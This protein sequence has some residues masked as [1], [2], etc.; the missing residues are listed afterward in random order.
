MAREHEIVSAPASALACALVSPVYFPG[1]AA[2][3][4]NGE[5]GTGDKPSRLPP[6]G[7]AAMVPTEEV[8]GRYLSET[9]CI[10]LFIRYIGDIDVSCYHIA[11]NEVKPS[12][13]TS[14][15]NLNNYGAKIGHIRTLV[16][17]DAESRSHYWLSVFAQDHGVVP[18]HGRQEV[19]V[20]VA[21]ENDNTPLTE[22]PVYYPSIAENSP[23]GKQVVQLRAV[24]FDRDPEQR[25]SFRITAGNPES[26][27]SIDRE[28][29]IIRTTGR[30]LD[31]ENQA[32][33]IL[34]VTVSDNGSPPLSST[35]RVVVTVA[36]VNDHA[37]QFEQSFY[38]IQIPESTSHDLPLFQVLGYD[39]DEGPNGDIT[40]SIKSGRGIGKFRIHPKTGVVYSQRGFQEGQEYDLRIRAQDNGLPQKSHTTR[41]SVQVMKVP[42][43]SPHPPEI[44]NPNQTVEVTESDDITYLV[45]L[46]QAIDDDGDMLWYDI[47]GGDDDHDFF[48]GRDKG[49]I[50][51]AKK[52]DWERK[53]KYNLTISV[54]D[55]VHTV[56]TQLYVT[57]IDINDCRPNFSEKVY[58]VE[59][60]E[61]VEKG[62]EILQL[63][64]T[65]DDEDKKVFYS[66]YAARNPASLSIFK[67]DSV[68]GAVVLNEKLDRETIE[69]HILTVM[70]KDQGTPSKRNY[71]RVVVTVHDHND[72]HPEFTSQII[73]GK[74]FETA[75]IGSAVVQVYA[76]DKDRGENAKIT[77]SITS[78]N[79][80][81]VFSIDPTLGT[82]QIAR[83]LDLGSMSE[84]MLIVKATDNGSPPLSSTIPVHVMVTMADNAPP[85]FMK[86]EHAAEIYENQPIG[87]YV[88]HLEARSTSSLFFEIIAG[89]TDDMYFINPSTG[90]IITKRQ[91]DY[92]L[93][94]VYNLT[95]E[96]TNMAG[97]KAKCNVIVHVLDRND[98]APRFVQALYMGSISEAAPVG[99]L[100][101]ANNSS[102]LVIKAKDDD[103]ELNALL[104][105]DIV[106]TLPRTYFRIDSST[107]A[108]RTVMALDHEKY[109]HFHFHVKV[110]DLGKPRL[111]SETTARVE[112][113]I[114]DVN[115]CSPHFLQSEYNTTL[116]L[117]TYQNVAVVRVNASDPDSQENT[118]LRYDIIDGNKGNVFAIDAKSGVVTVA[119]TRHIKQFHKL[120]LRVSDGKFSS[121][122][123][124]NIKVEKSE[125]SGLTFQKSVY[126]GTILENT[127]KISPVV[128]VNVLGSALNEHVVFSILNPTDMFTIGPTSGVIK[129]TGKRFDRELKDKYELIVEARSEEVDEE[130]PR[131]AHVMVNVTILDINDN[132]PMFVNLP[133]YAVVSVDAQKGDGI[134]KV[135]AV[136]MDKGENGEVRYELI[137]GHGELFKVCRKTGEVTLKQSLE[138]HNREYELIIAAY[139]GGISPCS[140]EVPV[141]VKV[142]DRSM[143]IFDKQFYTDSVP[144]S[145]EIHSPLTV[146]IQAE[147]PLGRKLIYSIVKGNDYEEF[148]LDFNTGVISV[149]DELDY[150]QKKQYELTI[151]ATDSV[152]GVYAEVLVSILVQDVNDCPPEFSTD[153]YNISV[154]EAAPFGTS[155]LKVSSRD[156]DTGIN[157]K[158]R[159]EIQGDSTNSSEYFHIDPDDGT[160]YLKR[161]LDHEIHNS[162]HFTVVAK[163][164]GVPSLSSTAHVWVTVLDM[165]DNPPK[166]EQPSYTCFLS[167][168]AQRGQ[169]VTVV[170]ASDP[171]YVD[172]ERLSYTIVGG[173]EL[174]TFSIDSA[175][176]IISLINMQ[177]FAEDTMS[178]LN[179][180]VTDGVYTSFTRV[181]IE[182]LP[183]N[184]HNPVF[185]KLQFEVK[186]NEN[187]PH[188]TMVTKVTA[189]DEDFGEYGEITYAIPSELLREIFD[190]NRKSGEITTK[191][192]LDREVQ[193]LYEIPVMATDGG[194]RSGFV[195][196]RVKV[197]DEN[198]NTPKFL[199][200]EYKA[201]IQNNLTI[202]SRILRIKAVD[203]DDDMAAD[204]LYSI[205]ETQTSG[206]K[207]L[208]TI[209]NHSGV[210]TLNRSAVP[211]ENQV[212]QF[213]VR[214]Q[215]RGS[216]SLYSNV[217]VDIYVMS[218]QD[219]AP[220]FERRDDK[221][222]ISE[223]D[224]PGTLITKLKM[225]TN[226]S[227]HYRIISGNE[228][229]PLF[230]VDSQGQLSLARTLDREAKDTHLIAVLAETDSS[231]PL[232]A[233]AEVTL[234][235]LDENDNM[236]E[237]ESS[238][239]RL[240]LA[241]NVGEGTSILKVIAHDRDLGSNGEVRY[242]FGSD[243]GD[244]ANVFAVDAYTGWITTL[245]QLDK[246]E[247]S[248]F[249]FQVV[250]TD[251]GNPKHFA[252][253]S[254]YIKLKDYNDNPPVFK[255]RHDEATVN[256]D[257]LPGTVVVQLETTDL[258]SDLISPVEF[259]IT[260]GDPQSQFQIR[261]TGEV[262][263]A[264]PLDR[265]SISKYI[266]EVTATD[267]KFIAKTK[268]R[269]REV[270][271]EGVHP[272][273]YVLTVL[274]N[275]IDEEPNANLRYYL[276][277][278][279]ADRFSLDKSGGHL[280]TI[281]PLDREEQSKYQ[282]TAHVQDRDKTGWECSSQIEILISDLNDNPPEFSMHSYSATLPEDVEVGTLV[283]KVHATDRDIGIN[284]KIKY[285][286]VDSAN[287]HFKIASDSGIVT[288]AKPLDRETRAM[289]NLSVQAI[290]QGTPQ[291]SKL[292]GLTV[293][294]LDIND[295]P[296]EFASKY[297]YASVPE[298]NAVGT[299]IVRVLATSKDA[300]VNAEVSYSIIGGN[301]H[302]KFAIHPKSGVITIADHLDYERAKDYFLTIQAVDGGVPPLSNHATVNISVTD[303]NDNAPVFNQVSYSARIREDAQIGDKI[304]QVL[305]T[306]L[307]SEANGKVTYS[308]ERGDRQKQFHINEKTGYISVAGT[309]DREM[310]SNYVLEVHA[311]DN[312]LPVMSS[313]VMVNIEISDA[314][315]N[316]PL[317]SQANYTAIVQ[318]DKPLH[319]MVLKFIVTDADANPNAAPYTYDIRS[320]NEGTAFML[321]QDGILRT[322]AKLNHKIRDK[323]YLHIR[324]FDN[325][326]P[327]LFSDT[328]VIVK[329]IEESQYPPHIT[330]LEISVN[331][332]MDEF[333]GGVIGKIHASDQDQFD[334]LSYS[335]AKTPTGNLLQNPA[336][337]LF[338][339]NRNDGTL[340]ALPRLD[341]GEY[342]INISVSD[343]KF[344]SNAIVKVSV[345][346]VSE[347]MLSNS[348]IIR[349]RDISPLDFV[350]SY[351]KGFRRA[352]GNSL[353]GRLKDVII[354]SIQPTSVELSKSKGRYT[355]QAQNSDLDVLFAVKKSQSVGGNT[356][357]HSADT[358]RQAI[359]GNIDEIEAGGLV[360]EEIARDKCTQSYCTYGECEDHI[361]LDKTSVTSISADFTSFV[362]PYHHHEVHCECKEGYAGDRCEIIVNE[363][364]RDPCP[365][366][367]VCI[368]DA[369]PQG[370]SCQCPEGFAGPTCEVDISKCHDESCYIPRNPVSFS[371]KS[372]AQYRV[373]NSLVK[374]ILENRMSL[375][376]RIRTMH[377]TGNLMYAAGKVDYNILEVENGVVQYRFDLGSGEGLVRVGSAYVSDGQWHEIQ[378]ERDGNSAKLVVD[379]KHVAHGSAP[380]NN[381]IL[382]LQST[383]IYLGAEVH[384]HPT[385]LGYEDIQRGFF[386]CMDDVRIARVSVPLHMS[387]ASSVA[388]LKRFA[389]VEF[390]CDPS[391]VLIP[392]GVCGSQPC[393]NGGTCIDNGG[394]DYD[395]TCHPRFTGS[396]CEIDTDPCASSP[397]LYGGRCHVVPMGN[398]FMCQCLPHSRFSGKRC[399]YGRFC[400]P[401]PCL[402]GGVCEE[403]DIGPICKCHGY[404]GDLCK[405]D[406]DECN[407]SARGP[408]QNGGTC[409]NEPGN[410]RC[411][412]P[413]NVTGRHC[414]T[415]LYSTSISSSK[416]NVTWEELIA[417]FVAVTI[418]FLVVFLFIMYRRFRVKRSRE[419]TNNINNETHKDIVLNSARPNDNEFKRGSK[420][421][422]LEVS[423][424]PPQCPPRP[425]SYTPSSNN[426]PAPYNHPA[427]MLN[428]LDT[429][430]SY[431]SAGDELENVPPDYLRNLNRSTPVPQAPPHLTSTN[432]TTA[433]TTSLDSDSLHKPSWAEVA[434]QMG[435]Y[436][437]T[438][439]IKND[440]KH[441]VA[442]SD[443]SR[444]MISTGRPGRGSQVGG[445]SATSVSSLDD[446]PRLVGGYHWDCSDWVN[447]S[448]NPLPNITEV[449]GSEVPDSSSFHSNESNE[450]N[451]HQGNMSLPP[452]LGPVDPVRDIETLNEDQESEYVGDSECGTEFGGSHYGPDS[453][454]L[455]SSNVLDS[456]GE[457][458]H[459]N[460]ASSYLRHPNQY[461]PP[462]NINSENETEP[463]SSHNNLDDSDDEE[464]VPYGFPSRRRRRKGEDEDGSVITVLGERASLLGGCTSNSDLSTNLCDIDD[465]EFESA[466][467]KKFNQR[468]WISAGITQTSV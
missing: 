157:Q 190:I 111:S 168:H 32:E 167:E 24:D 360:V 244:L 160:I 98:N 53:N 103:S 114:L 245:V 227:V 166:F 219:V 148:A 96:A 39:L 60:S 164:G 92:E 211:W 186:V 146:S 161:S 208:F 392:P 108:I 101:L 327:P 431:G 91:L 50:L 199:L 112:I 274:A 438:N 308:I 368:P 214:A 149:V 307:D 356:A 218:S 467:M 336:T 340:S 193:K 452:V 415:S 433:T 275:D 57:V 43:T 64:A 279:G 232:T 313:Y 451:T 281:R 222:F 45:A 353:K 272:G 400:N 411:V 305:A 333:P 346:L 83:E 233:L 405:L 455:Q 176:G 270:L 259:Y 449:P 130:R 123:Q 67:V 236:P 348:V 271:S 75:S 127:T 250:A 355:R 398:D 220:M 426:E 198:D 290:D 406:V 41:V 119:D 19:Y 347:E 23:A 459:F 391:T 173:N 377:L 223:N 246:E 372:Y 239:Y 162:H 339:I 410:Y 316:Q 349:F 267:G 135:H 334:T 462:Y 330:P 151:R 141:H 81:N 297:Y 428:N 6:G 153:A 276:T 256:E 13:E 145:I 137:K 321:E 408:C 315:D 266:L 14:K 94:K 463:L 31:R 33:H 61:N 105:Y 329:V 27:F 388:V 72:H 93:N 365:V 395:C 2:R 143:P 257:A 62:T 136:D 156:N 370:F 383:D 318:E 397:C 268:Y 283:T 48:I 432:P 466:E 335:L 225:V 209:N 401:N 367:K 16:P 242:S 460:T 262:Y 210:I 345:E 58:N 419:R 49:N 66:L 25:L 413:P 10:I 314:N 287:G 403:G 21:N 122:A 412:C 468:N 427:A 273:S 252:R 304:L 320:G 204:I 296:P 78:G 177:N 422:N 328:W 464:V 384:Q 342:R 234:K 9:L 458:Y 416:Y 37:P 282:L 352:V 280:K 174:Q 154:S 99:S 196:V 390:N 84:Y 68:T 350:L 366:F 203:A 364:A 357:F 139:D 253:T 188:G 393:L 295:N 381:G 200:R 213:F 22:E 129:T 260:S 17:L 371:G 228:D 5:G 378:L 445:T 317:F 12:H 206:V 344:T 292:A 374:K 183:A 331:S 187:Q 159:Y 443:F 18:L 456:G 351:R 421:S 116:L 337:D 299:E 128:V 291:L 249:V 263:V 195:I 28:T 52:L 44:K 134:T 182:I 194:G 71:A 120:H 117:P 77:Y 354:I 185:P 175:T 243:I 132:C 197:G 444:G 131:V 216:P 34:E 30:K 97:A 453:P 423:Q 104:S 88:K 241:E 404:T 461:L 82:V 379:G 235:V 90:V 376:L 205:Y 207:E 418:I 409:Y 3:G 202:N 1:A 46:I 11:L 247:Q 424:V 277:G 359:N 147:S 231:P 110:S 73:Q 217:P 285:S 425:A 215:D 369:S 69:E 448:Q 115:D 442:S 420:L 212:F 332:F 429:L 85:R 264:K 437:D 192:K 302:K 380:G 59:I 124:V 180:S 402:N 362:S 51:L 382:N 226:V 189:S 373:D 42:K 322:A 309:L 55:G 54:T 311:R 306:D 326:T 133:Y 436:T 158:V 310:V 325:G 86:K 447:R 179:I 38:K 171:D 324:V 47:V 70:V 221:F 454:N 4:A 251:N 440:L 284:R 389:N 7:G 430:R 26:Y 300:G 80:G 8:L 387:G 439:K 155:V 343:G 407:G 298:I 293:L 172:Y 181:Q 191:K 140:T 169:F 56:Y 248:E 36:D 118:V 417:I 76:I 286:F 79:I 29:G 385:V 434:E 238:P 107:G 178:I 121:V 265:E 375:S 125:N 301:E 144:E 35:T 254:V 441:P 294:V 165:N 338:E 261:Q 396:S 229:A 446:D 278:E 170:K 303:S 435:T 87:T 152:S 399:E 230:A 258:D 312:G 465:S 240:T 20:A 363:C 269:Y 95:V 106:E 102:P 113:T 138:G 150:E 74:V 142:I 319:H 289:Y 341:V 100:I 457:E 163:D 89:N 65:D 394:D 224:P 361:V 237:F 386:G 15:H 358:V 126:L 184:R 414:A 109:A 288:L 63:L 201:T 40:Y 323:Y 450:S 255:S